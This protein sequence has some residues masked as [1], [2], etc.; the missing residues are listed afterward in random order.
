M[1]IQAIV[2][3][4]V[5]EHA[6]RI[7]MKAE[8]NDAAVDTSKSDEN[9]A[10]PT[11]DAASQAGADGDGE[12]AAGSQAAANAPAD[13]A[14]SSSDT[15]TTSSAAKGKGKAPAEDAAKKPAEP[16]KPAEDKKKGKNLVGKINNLV[17]SDLSNLEP[18]GMLVT[19][20]RTFAPPSCNT[21][22]GLTRWSSV[23]ISA[24]DHALHGL[25]VPASRLEVGG[26]G[27]LCQHC[28]LTILLVVPWSVWQLC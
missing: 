10:A 24:A 5:F 3:E 6:L 22:I 15:A 4:L 14:A 25:P 16:K 20:A 19:V 2:T 12:S 23:R 27:C 1:R 11:P 21:Y 28:P 26:P 17:T 8:T 18:I 7:R 9:T 13:S